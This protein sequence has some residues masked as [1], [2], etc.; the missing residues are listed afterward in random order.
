MRKFLEKYIGDKKFYR[1]VLL[2]TIPI[3]IQ[4][5]ITN[6]VSLLDNIMVG[7]IGTEQMS[8]VAIVNQ[9][10]LVYNICIF[11]AVSGAG[12]FGA[13]FYGKG[14]HKGVRDAFRFKMVACLVLAVIWMVLFSFAGENLIQLFLHEGEGDGD[15]QL[16]LLYA[17]KYLAAVMPSMIPFALIQAYAQTLRETGETVLPMVAG[18]VSV[19]VNLIFD[20]CM[21]FGE[22]GFPKLGVVGAAVAT[23]LARVVECL[24]VIAWTHCHAE[25]NLFIVGAYRNFCIPKQ[26]V[27]QIIIK[28]TP[29]LLNE[30]LWAGGQAV[31]M[32]CYSKRG[33]EIVAAFNISNTVANL[34]NVAFLALG[35][36]IAI[37]VGQLLGAGRLEEAV[38]TDRKMIVFSVFCCVVIGG[39]MFL[40]AP[41]FPQ[42]YNT[43]EMV[44]HRA[45]D[46]I[47]VA[48]L[49]M[50]LY[51]FMHATYFT[52][53]S[54]GKTIIT[55]LFDSVYVWV[56]SIPL[57]FL[58]TTYAPLDILLIY[59]IVQL[60]EIIKCLIGYILVKKRV[61][62]NNVVA[63]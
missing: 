36:A 46:F 40:F 23:V 31:L 7:R 39:M 52:L 18:V 49:C 12:I 30:T 56:A 43:S 10:M 16:T 57:A 11:G 53:R 26:L 55:F 21:I 24:I 22:F 41:L 32:Q 60:A 38:D 51:G 28:G 20:Y 37:V 5:G 29:L 25:K 1:M 8:G 50:P 44:R 54:G 35:S 61:W 45:A 14:D 62:V 48:S 15:I 59:L 58:L 33:I 42:I 13:Q 9:L 4:N 19:I 2:V 27:K 34:F 6:L 3:M 47:R 63:E 17:R